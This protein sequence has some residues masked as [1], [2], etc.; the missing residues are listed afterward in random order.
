MTM[1]KKHPLEVTENFGDLLIQ[2]LE[3]AIAAEEGRAKPARVSRRKIT[4]RRADVAPPPSYNRVD[5]VKVRRSLGVSQPVFA[6][7]LNVS[8]STVRASEQGARVPEGATL[9]LLEIADKHPEVLVEAVEARS[10][11]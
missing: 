6:S 9:R 10:A 8:R 3:E 4:A 1:A 5:I 7:M 11:R 2:G